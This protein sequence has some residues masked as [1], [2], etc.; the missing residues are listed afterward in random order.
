VVDGSV[1]LV[2]L[3]VG[4][5][6]ALALRARQGRPW[7][8]GIDRGLRLLATAGVLLAMAR[9]AATVAGWSRPDSPA[10]IYD[11]EVFYGAGRAIL[12][13]QPLYDLA[14][15]RRDPGRIVVYRHAPVGAAIFAPL[16]LL[17]FRLALDLWRLLHVALYVASL[18]LLLRHFRVSPRAPLALGLTS[19]WLV[20]APGRDSL[21]SGQW[22]TPFLFATTAALLLFA[23]GRDGWAGACLALP[24]AIKFYPALLLLGPLLER[25][26]RAL[27]GCA[28]A[29]GALMLAGLL[30]GGPDDT[31]VFVREVLPAVGGG[32]LYYENQAPYAL[33]GRL[34]ATELRGN[35]L[36]AAYPA[37]ATALVARGVAA[38]VILASALAIRRDGGG[39]LGSALRLAT[40]TSASLLIIPTAWG[41]YLTWLV[42]PLAILGIAIAR[43]PLGWP[44]AACFAVA[45]LL[46][47]FG[48]ERTVWG[49]GQHD[50]A[51]RLVL[52]YK[53][54]GV[55]ALWAGAALAA[56]AAAT[57]APHGANVVGEVAW[58]GT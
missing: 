32:T 3:G 55:A 50:G 1:V 39:Q 40:L 10:N 48:V 44:V 27:G 29:G 23:R 4:A 34:L 14:G 22:D 45:A 47:P 41:I 26:Y 13:G 24:V 36:D 53:A 31:R 30:A 35:G 8:P 58:R 18:A 37:R 16:A 52:T 46:L 9:F 54:Y 56:R 28:L 17:P 43:R 25:R 42:L 15:I 51:I 7:S 20:S 33:I 5:A 2:A 6:F 57:S 38:L 19:L 11:F 21:A 12:S 49:P